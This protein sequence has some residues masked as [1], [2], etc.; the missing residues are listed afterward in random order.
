[1][2]M[3]TKIVVSLNDIFAI[4]FSFT[5]V[6]AIII[7]M[8]IFKAKL[9]METRR[10]LTHSCMGIWP[11]LWLLFENAFAAFIV[12]LVVT[13]LLAVAPQNV[14]ALFSKGEEKHVGL[15]IYALSFTIITFFL[16][17]TSIG[18][19]AIFTLAFADGVSGW[20]G[21]KYGKHMYQVP[22]SK[23]KSLEGSAGMFIASLISIYIAQLFYEPIFSP[24]LV[25]A[26][27]IIATI[28]EG[29]SPKH[30]DNIFVPL[31][32]ATFI[33]CLHPIL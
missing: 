25:I 20:I 17:R 11:I 18:T 4:I 5:Y 21:R 2:E 26:G 12:P 24:L 28:V 8:K 9:D 10:K 32:L 29:I 19:A 31:I 6:I 15:V 1:M 33:Y 30:S 3:V 16:Y 13:I 14:R 23:P 27:A 22:W 7:L